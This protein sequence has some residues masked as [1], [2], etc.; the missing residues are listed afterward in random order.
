MVTVGLREI[1]RE[2]LRRQKQSL[3]ARS[4]TT[5]LTV[6]AFQQVRLADTDRAVNEQGSA[7]CVG[8]LRR[9]P[10]C[11]DSHPVTVANDKFGQIGE[12]A[13]RALGRCVLRTRVL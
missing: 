10:H 13:S 11:R 9:L 2:L 6:Q 3:Q 1:V 4:G 5:N 8:A 12:A 7:S